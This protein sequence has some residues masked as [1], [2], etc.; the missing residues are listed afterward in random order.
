[1]NTVESVDNSSGNI[2][3]SCGWNNSDTATYCE[4]CGDKL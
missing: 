2:C 3:K 4:N 1:V